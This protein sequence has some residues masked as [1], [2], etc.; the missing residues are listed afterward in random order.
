MLFMKQ[1]PRG[2]LQRVKLQRVSPTLII[3][4]LWDPRDLRLE[5]PEPSM[6]EAERDFLLV[7][8]HKINIALLRLRDNEL[9]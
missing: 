2:S 6:T 7:A 3:W 1:L 8:R 5:G 4:K 9:Y